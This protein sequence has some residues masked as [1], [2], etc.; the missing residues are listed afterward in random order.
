M[1]ADASIFPAQISNNTND[2]CYALGE[3]AAR[4]L[5]AAARP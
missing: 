1:V 4:R 3:M 5:G 2:L